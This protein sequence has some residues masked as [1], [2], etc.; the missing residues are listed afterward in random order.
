MKSK[1]IIWSRNRACQ[2]ETLLDSIEKFAPRSFDINVIWSATDDKFSEGYYRLW[3][4][5]Y[6]MSSFRK[7]EGQGKKLLMDL[8]DDN[9]Y[10]TITFATDDTILYRSPPYDFD[11]RLEGVATFSL[12][13]GLNTLTQDCFAHSIQPPLIDYSHEGYTIKWDYLKYAPNHN[14]GFPF[15][16]DM[17]VYNRSKFLTWIKD[18]NFDRPS[19]LEGGLQSWRNKLPEHYIRS[20]KQSI[21]VNVPITNLT[22]YTTSCN[23]SIADVNKK[24]L[25]G[26]KIRYN[27]NDVITGA[28][29]VLRYEWI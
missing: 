28:H 24:F 27:L 10:N 6:P 1:L 3:G 20:F 22:G 9:H 16:L 19:E 18:L 15:G 21:A 25:D 11:N 13:Y 23:V 29:Q 12:R 5:N 14:Y 17:H 4:F 26:Q 7:Q 2:L 8:V